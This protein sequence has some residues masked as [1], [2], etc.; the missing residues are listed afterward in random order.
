MIR[1]APTAGRVASEAV[2]TGSSRNRRDPCMSRSPRR[3]RQDQASAAAP[4]PAAHRRLPTKARTRSRST[5]LG[6]PDRDPARNE[7]WMRREPRLRDQ[8]QEDYVLDR[9]AAWEAAVIA[10]DARHPG[11]KPPAGRNYFPGK[12]GRD[13]DSSLTFSA[14]AV[15]PV[16][17]RNSSRTISSG[18]GARDRLPSPLIFY[19]RSCTRPT[20]ELTAS[21]L[22]GRAQTFGHHLTR[23]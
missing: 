12:D 6:P 22:S 4:P 13:E 16:H 15:G 19:P 9:E 3:G 8:T 1:R 5:H 14:R 10:T 17:D 20:R 21:P 11:A 7:G 2:D 23:F 18:H